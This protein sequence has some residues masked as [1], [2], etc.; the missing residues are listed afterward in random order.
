MS[1]AT[2]LPLNDRTMLQGGWIKGVTTA[3]LWSGAVVL[4][5]AALGS[6][7]EAKQLAYSWCFSFL[8][9]FTVVAG[10]LFWTLVHHATGAGWST[11]LRRLMENV[12]D[13]F[14]VIAVLFLPLI[15]MGPDLYEWMQPAKAADHVVQEKALYLNFPF[16]LVRAAGYFAVFIG[17]AYF[18]RKI[19]VRQDQDGCAVYSVQL[20]KPVYLLS[21]LAGLCLIFASFDWIMALDYHWYSTM[22]PVTIVAGAGL[23]GIAVLI[24]HTLL[25]KRLGYLAAVGVEHYHLLGKVLFSFVCFWGW[26]SLGQYLFIWY[27]NIPEETIFFIERNVGSWAVIC[28][29]S[30]V[31]KVVIPFIGLLL[32]AAKRNPLWLGLMAGSVLL[33]HA[34]ELYWLV[35]PQLHADGWTPHWLDVV[36]WLGM[37]LVLCSFLLQKATKAA[38]YP[39]KDPRLLESVECY[40]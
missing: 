22:F 35:L 15:V 14:P 32:Q 40:N 37:F 34:L 1:T 38:I 23:A 7:T 11:L 21:L 26:V 36:C 31:F 17:V 2:T 16:W 13:L 20:Q 39:V 8:F 24:L 25:L 19:S 12:A 18:Y 33:G 29:L 10:S 6:L 5:V 9:F 27:A 4:L 28:V 3:L 30:T